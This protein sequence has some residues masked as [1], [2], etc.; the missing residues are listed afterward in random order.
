[1]KNKGKGILIGICGTVAVAGIAFSATALAKNG[2]E[3]ATVEPEQNQEQLTPEKKSISSLIFNNIQDQQYT[4]EAIVPAVIVLDGTK[5]L[6]KDTDFT[7][8]YSKNINVGIA[9]ILVTGKGDYNETKTI[10]FNIVK[11]ANA[12][13]EEPDVETMSSGESRFGTPEAY[14]KAKGSADSTYIRLYDVD[15]ELLPDEDDFEAISQFYYGGQEVTV[16]I[17]VPESET[18]TGLEKVV[19]FVVPYDITVEDIANQAYTG[20]AITP[21]FV[22]R[23]V[24]TQQVLTAGTDY[25]VAYSNNTNAGTATAVITFKGNYAGVSPITKTFVIEQQVVVNTLAYEFD[26]AQIKNYTGQESQV[27]IPSSYSLGELI[28]LERTT[29]F[30]YTPTENDEEENENDTNTSAS[31]TEGN[32]F[33]SDVR[34]W[35]SNNFPLS[36]EKLNV[37]TNA[38]VYGNAGGDTS[39]FTYSL[40]NQNG[41]IYNLSVTY[42]YQ[43][44]IEGNDVQVT[45]IANRAFWGKS[46]IT[47]ITIPSTITSI[48]DSAFEQC[49]GLVN[50][51][52]PSTVQSLGFNAFANNQGLLSVTIEGDIANP[53]NW[54]FNNCQNLASVSM[55]NLT[56]FAYGMFANC[57]S[58]TSVVIPSGVTTIEVST[59]SGSGLTSITIPENVTVIGSEAFARCTSLA[60]VTFEGT[61]SVATIGAGAFDGCTALTNVELP[62]SVAEI[63]NF[64]FQNCLN[65]QSLT[66]KSSSLITLGSVIVDNSVIIYVSS[67]LLASYQNTYPNYTFMADPA[68]VV[69]VVTMNTLSKEYTGQE[70]VLDNSG[71][72]PDIEISY[73]GTTFVLGTDYTLSYANNTNVGTVDVIINFI[74]NYAG[75]AQQTTSFLITKAYPTWI[76]QPSI[77]QVSNTSEIQLTTGQT[78]IGSENIRYYYKHVDDADWTEIFGNFTI[79]QT[80]QYKFKAELTETTNYYA[81]GMQEQFL[82]ISEIAPSSN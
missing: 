4:G 8:A 30:D 33:Y 6:V 23:D 18:Y 63:E 69:P 82:T 20:E 52:I 45:S 78:S 24:D 32:S 72:T 35:L 14:I 34:N 54:T 76:T 22:V 71:L 21:T 36:E 53:G 25:D 49:S 73:N 59:F 62:A 70:I 5:Q 37:M 9:D 80:G 56:T 3:K 65:L 38:I 51:T 7:L 66:I 40:N 50:V 74:G 16:K 26:G 75:V 12:W 46:N 44:Y 61:S 68:T 57:N 47:S 77:S 17:I 55:P 58:L 79:S 41:T 67:N 48:G 19:N 39:F 10:H 60:S 29:T 28:T 27:D 42:T 11:R 2:F 64:A 43:Q 81:L 13:V 31:D 1:M 15:G